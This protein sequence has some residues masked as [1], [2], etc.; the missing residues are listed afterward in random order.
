VLALARVNSAVG[1]LLASLSIQPM[2][3]L[4][5]IV[6]LV[7]ATGFGGVEA[8]ACSC[9]FS[10]LPQS[11][12]QQVTSARKSSRAIFS[13]VVLKT[14]EVGYSVQVTFKV[15]SFWKGSLPS[16]VVLT[17]GRGGGDCGYRFEVGDRY[18]VYAY[19]SDVRS[20]GTNICQRTAPYKD[21]AT[22]LKILGKTK[23]PSS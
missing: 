10:P 7:I 11:Q 21:A 12:K 18:L 2:K 14:K 5:S 1:F 13:G 4:F 20:L 8:I 17:T 9:D 19:G 22:D 23:R 6:V 16:E 15:D 3:Q